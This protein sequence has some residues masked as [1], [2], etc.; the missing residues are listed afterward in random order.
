VVTYA[1]G[2]HYEGGIY[3]NIRSAYYPTCVL[4]VLGEGFRFRGVLNF[5]VQDVFL[6][7][8]YGEHHGET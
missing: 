8:S 2:S 4:A 7:F 6:G 3:A 1:K 5:S